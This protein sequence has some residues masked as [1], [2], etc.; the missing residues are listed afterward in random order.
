MSSSGFFTK[1]Q[2]SC[3][4][5]SKEFNR[6]PESRVATL[7]NI[8]SYIR[9]K[10]DRNELVNLIVICTHNSRRS[11][12]GQLWLSMAATWY[13]IEGLQVYSGGTEATAFHPNAVAALRRTG[14][15]L[16]RVGKGSN[17]VY[18]AK[19]GEEFEPLQLFSKVYS[20]SHNPRKNFAAIMVCSEADEAC[21]IV[22]GADRRFSLPFD[23]PKNFD[24]TDLEV[25]KYDEACRLI[26]REMLL[27]VRCATER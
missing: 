17:P 18:E 12:M 20:D 23:D 8:G 26:A 13:G 21:P 11:H 22:F 3:D 25:E 6:I 7:K 14:F 16:T 1:L 19:I 9:E 27:A 4:T 2:H 5:F 24:N 15:D 10:R